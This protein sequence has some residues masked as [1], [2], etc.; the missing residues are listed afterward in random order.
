MTQVSVA[1]AA[2]LVG[3]D[4]KTLYRSIKEGKLSATLSATGQRQVDVTELIRV[5]GE[6]KNTRDSGETVTLPQSETP[7][8][9]ARLSAL[10]AENKQLRERLVD[11]DRHI[12]DM[13]NTV[14]LLE[15][16]KKNRPWWKFWRTEN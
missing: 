9:S 8:E 3:R 6:L 4:R 2:N 11:K 12:E 13:R 16:K 5:F 10:E 15:F 1:E 14:R 7:N